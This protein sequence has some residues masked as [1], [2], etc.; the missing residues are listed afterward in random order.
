MTFTISIAALLVLAAYLLGAIPNGFIVARA[1]GIDIRTVGSGNIGATNVFRSVSKPLGL[2]TFALDALKGFGPAMFFPK[3]IESATGQPDHGRYFSI[4][5]AVATVVGHN[6][7]VFMRF[8]GGKGVA[9]AAGALLAIIPASIGLGFAIWVVF[10]AITRYVSIASIATS[11]AVGGVTWWLYRNAYGWPVPCV[12]SLLA[13]IV[14]WQHRGNIR[15]LC[16]GTEHRFTFGRRAN[17]ETS[18]P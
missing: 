15:R 13:V 16:A 2:L 11:I 12:T 18:T 3:L 10:F 6:W 7:T 4:L 8:K 17:S 5:F 14:I 9:T 1:R